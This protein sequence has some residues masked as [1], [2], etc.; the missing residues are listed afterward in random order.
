MRRTDERDMTSFVEKFNPRVS[1]G[2]LLLLAGL[3]WAVVGLALI[4]VAERWLWPESVPVRL[5]Y[6]ALAIATGLAVQRFGFSKIVEKNLARLLPMKDKRCVFGFVPW[7]SYLII[8]VMVGMGRLLRMSPLPKSCLAI[9]YVTMGLAMFLSS[10]RY[11]AE[12]RQQQTN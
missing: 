2:V 6:T 9:V 10:L 5:I 7:K 3:M 8:I 11:F 1:R 12:L 4:F